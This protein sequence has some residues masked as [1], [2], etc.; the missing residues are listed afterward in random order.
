MKPNDASKKSNEKL[1]YSNLKDNREAREPEFK[2]GQLV[3]TAG[4]K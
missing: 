3:H 4:I 1:V 2:L